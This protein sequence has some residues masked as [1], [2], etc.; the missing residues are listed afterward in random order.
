[1]AISATFIQM[2]PFS[3]QLSAQGMSRIQFSGRNIP[4]K[5]ILGSSHYQIPSFVADFLS[6]KISSLHE[7]DPTFDVYEVI[8]SDPLGLFP[9]FLSLGRGRKLEIDDSNVEFF[10]R[11]SQE[12]EN[13]ELLDLITAR[14][15]G[16]LNV[17]TVYQRLIARAAKGEETTEELRFI[18]EHFLEIPVEVIDKISVD[19]LYVLFSQD[20]F[21]VGNHDKLFEYIV[22]RYEKDEKGLTLLEFVE[23][24]SLSE[25]SVKRFTEIGHEAFSSIGQAVW[26]RV[27]K[28]LAMPVKTK[29]KGRGTE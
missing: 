19:Y 17:Q 12:L 25:Q 3:I 7:Q 15:S 11:L 18:V 13:P 23:F 22:H 6:K 1:M 8:T 16:E 10:S 24:E 29:P 14:F 4:F 27:F 21:T 2:Q 28:R 9:K 26:Q 20:D 5:F